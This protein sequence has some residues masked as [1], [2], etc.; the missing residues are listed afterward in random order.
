MGK[1]AINQSGESMKVR[2]C[3]CGRLERLERTLG[4]WIRNRNLEV[5]RQLKQLEI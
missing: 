5:G 1:H 4:Y 2:S 3:L